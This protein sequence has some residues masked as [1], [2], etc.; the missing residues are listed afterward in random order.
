MAVR[1]VQLFTRWSASWPHNQCLHSRPVRLPTDN[2]VLHGLDGGGH[3][4]PFLRTFSVRPGM[5]RV[6][7]WNTVGCLPSKLTNSVERTPLTFLVQTL[8]TTY[9]SEVVPTVLR[10][11]VT[12]YVCMCWGAGILLSSGVVRAVAG[13]DGDLAW[14]LPFAL[15][16]VW[17]IPLF[18]G[19]Y[20]APES[21]W[22]AVRRNKMDLARKSLTRL[23][24]DT[25][26]KEQTVEA[27]LA[28]IKYVT[29]LEQAETA[30]ASFLD[31][32]RGTNLRRTEIVS[33]VH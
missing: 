24:Q 15:Q 8:S 19:A 32:F 9:A 21:P 12:A 18:I 13:I 4:H 22:N 27:S 30:N 5:G 20:L 2:D 16:W 23:H 10:P 33:E 17:P 11:Y 6:D 14:R 1:T 25:P 3:L 26:D 29:D 31:C 28:Y 7:V